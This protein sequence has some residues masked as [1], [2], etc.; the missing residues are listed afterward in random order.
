MLAQLN[1]L[2]KRNKKKTEIKEKRTYLRFPENSPGGFLR[3]RLGRLL[4]LRPRPSAMSG[5]SSASP[6]RPRR[7]GG[8]PA[9]R[10]PSPSYPRS[11]SVSLSPFPEQNL[12]LAATAPSSTSPS[13]LPPFHAFPD[14]SAGPEEAPRRHLPPHRAVLAGVAAFHRH[15]RITASITAG[16]LPRFRPPRVLPVVAEHPHATRVSRRTAPFP[17]PSS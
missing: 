3:N 10:S 15:P 5:S 1:Q 14:Q 9:R 16:L 2:L 6:C 8:P 12:T 11:R 4:L 17:F 7:G 13:P